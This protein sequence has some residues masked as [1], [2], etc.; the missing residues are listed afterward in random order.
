MGV[1][2]VWALYGRGIPECGAI[3]EGTGRKSVLDRLRQ[4]YPAA[5]VDSDR[6]FCWWPGLTQV[7]RWADYR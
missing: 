6:S 3:I 4:R 7:G 2:H 1:G 5:V